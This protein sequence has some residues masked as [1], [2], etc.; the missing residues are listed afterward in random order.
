MNGVWEFR[1]RLGEGTDFDDSIKIPVTALMKAAERGDLEA[2]K[3]N[4]SDIRK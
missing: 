1:R 2:I 4:L 3:A